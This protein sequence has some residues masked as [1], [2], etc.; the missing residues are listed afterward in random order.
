MKMEWDKFI[1]GNM[2]VKCENEKEFDEF[3]DKCWLN[4]GSMME[5]DREKEFENGD[6]VFF[7]RFKYKLELSDD[8]IVKMLKYD[9]DR[10]MSYKYNELK[11]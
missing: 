6:S 3:L 11:F 10:I 4:T 1:R 2:F 5:V 8:K 7:D 9:D